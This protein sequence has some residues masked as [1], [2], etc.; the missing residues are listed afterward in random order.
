MSEPLLDFLN[1]LLQPPGDLLFFLAIFALGQAALFLALG[2]RRRS[3]RALAPQRYVLATGLLFLLWLVMAGAAALSMATELSAPQLMPP[4]ERLMQA[5]AI[6]LLAWAFLNADPQPWRQANATVLSL[7]ALLLLLY[8]YTA[9]EWFLA[10][11]AGGFNGSVFAPVWSGLA[12]IIAAASLLITFANA[13]QLPDAPLKSL[14]FLLICLGNGWDLLQ[15]SQG[16]LE[17]SY[18][19]GARWAFL[20]AMIILPAIVYR[21]AVAQLEN[22]LAQAA[23]DAPIPPDRPDPSPPTSDEARSDREKL[24][25]S[26]SRMLDETDGAGAPERVTRALVESLN[27]EVC[28]LLRQHDERYAHVSAGHDGVQKRDLPTITIN[29]DESP[30]LRA[31]MQRD[32]PTTLAADAQDG[33]MAD[34]LRRLEIESAGSMRLQPLAGAAQQRAFLL[35]GMPYKQ[36]A[37][38][39]QQLDLLQDLAA[40]IPRILAWQGADDAEPKA[41]P[42]TDFDDAGALEAIQAARREIEAELTPI[43]DENA[44]LRNEIASLRTQLVDARQHFCAR[45]A[46]DENGQDLTERLTRHFADETRLRDNLDQRSRQLLEAQT[47]ASLISPGD[48]SLAAIIQGSQRQ[49]HERLTGERDRLQHHIDRLPQEGA[50]AYAALLSDEID[51]AAAAHE[52]LERRLAEAR[53]EL[54]ALGIAPGLDGMT[55]ALIQLHSERESGARRIGDLMRESRDSAETQRQ[56]KQL[57]AEH[58]A[59]L[60]LRE[61]MRRDYLALQE[62]LAEE[63]QASAGLQSEIADLRA[64]LAQSHERQDVLNGSIRDLRQERDNLL[65]IREGLTSKIGELL[66]ERG[67]EGAAE[68]PQAHDQGAGH[69]PRPDLQEAGA[70]RAGLPPSLL[71]DMQDPLKAIAD[72]NQML[73]SESIGILGAAQLQVLRH[74]SD[75]ISQLTAL[76]DDMSQIEPSGPEQFALQYAEA[77]M[78][79]LLDE[80][81]RIHAELIREKQLVIELSL[82]DSLPAIAM[83]VSCIQGTVTLL[84]QNACHASAAGG[85]I[86]IALASDRLLLPGSASAIDALRLTIEDSGTGIAPADI[87]RIFARHYRQDNPRIDGL[88]ET[89]P[90]LAVARAFARAHQGELWIDSVGGAGSAFHLALPLTPSPSTER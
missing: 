24:L 2:Q 71:Q 39:R 9:F 43:A 29:L 35:A 32:L 66:S 14:F 76:L 19:G 75:R 54:A 89:G 51:A 77:D 58:E 90:G 16:G 52:D 37:P 85:Q 38:S 55:Q 72:G 84:L 15:L 18:L 33:E 41:A 53:K 12:L 42:P 20:G 69:Q 50:D 87:P 88:S 10:L 25:R 3:P 67:A 45:L 40:F 74:I 22:A 46:D 82:G 34:L 83:D 65:R 7:S 49:V 64:K 81:L 61:D 48:D 30:G 78:V 11:D 62:K 59:L 26:L 63:N 17:G 47:L 23:L 13:S 86:H 27:Y 70:I 60:D 57:T 73:L 4:L 79:A 68:L 21:A 56:L 8:L 5:L 36:S 1:L 28:A 44:A 6:T 31:A 80:A